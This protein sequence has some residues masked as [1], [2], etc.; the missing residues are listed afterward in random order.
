MKFYRCSKSLLAWKE[1]PQVSF[2]WNMP[3]L[4]DPEKNV[5]CGNSLKDS[6]PDTLI[7]IMMD[8]NQREQLFESLYNLEECVAKENSLERYESAQS[9]VKRYLFLARRPRYESIELFPFKETLCITSETYI[10][11]PAYDFNKHRIQEQNLY[12]G[13]C[14]LS[15][16]FAEEIISKET[17]SEIQVDLEILKELL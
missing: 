8:N 13:G 7:V 1:M 15:E 12:N 6:L 16:E 10:E 17:E 2:K 3:I 9:E 4:I 14:Y 5:I 11:P